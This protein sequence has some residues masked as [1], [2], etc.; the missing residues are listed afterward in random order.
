MM[1]RSFVLLVF[2]FCKILFAQGKVDGAAAIVGDNII[3]HSD[4]LQRAQFAARERGVDPSKSPY[5]FEEIYL[6]TLNNIVDQY[7]V[8]SFAEKDTNIIISN[9]EVERALNQQIDNFIIQSGSEEVFL[10]MAGMSMHQ[11]RSEY[12]K[13]IRDMMYVERLQFLKIQ[14]VDVSRV[15]VNSFFNVY[16]DSLPVVLEQ[17]S[18]SVIEIPFISGSISEQKVFDFL[19]DLKN[20]VELFDASFDSLAKIHSHD[21]GTSQSGGFLGF[22]VRGSLVKEYEEVAYS[23][24]PGEISEPV[25]TDFGYHIIR[26]IDKQ[27]EKISTQHIL[28]TIEFSSEDKN[29]TIGSLENI[30]S[31]VEKKPSVFDSLASNYSKKYGNLSGTYKNVS[32]SNIP[33]LLLIEL[34]GFNDF[35]KISSIIKTEKGVALIFYY[36]HFDKI[37]PNLD[38]SWNLIYNYAKQKK[39]NKLF[40]EWVE[41]I[42]YK[43]FIKL[44]YN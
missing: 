22:T 25:K 13:D 24:L 9:D 7:V 29:L 20:N 8:L 10:E 32:V 16:K 34:M 39:Q 18:F 42:K 30:L 14:N 43:T 33:P 35:P 27:G 6:S 5:L 19:S 38:N 41:N 1:A 44:L 17:Y 31:Y 21:P 2:C 12:W 26:L 36:N 28:R 3:L 15:E 23:L 40:N 11:I 4:V 37:K